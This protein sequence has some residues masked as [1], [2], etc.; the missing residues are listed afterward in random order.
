MRQYDDDSVLH[1]RMHTH[2]NI[3][4][5]LHAGI[6]RE[7]EGILGHVFWAAWFGSVAIRPTLSSQDSRMIAFTMMI[8]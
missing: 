8:I 3:H 5:L 4:M 2:T 1:A 6:E 7:R